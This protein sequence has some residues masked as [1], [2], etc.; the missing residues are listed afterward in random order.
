MPS[1]A[2]ITTLGTLGPQGDPGLQ[3]KSLL[4]RGREARNPFIFDAMNS[5]VDITYIH[6]AFNDQ[7]SAFLV[8]SVSLNWA[9]MELQ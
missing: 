3:E 4:T 8:H 1:S 7:M 6:F 9:M 2:P 5:Q